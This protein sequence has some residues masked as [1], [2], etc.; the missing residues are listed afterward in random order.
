MQQINLELLAGIFDDP[1]ITATFEEIV[2][3]YTP[4]YLMGLEDLGLTKVIAEISNSGEVIANRKR[5]EQEIR[6]GKRN[7]DSLIGIF[8]GELTKASKKRVPIGR[9]TELRA[10]CERCDVDVGFGLVGQDAPQEQRKIT[11]DSLIYSAATET[12]GEKGEKG[13]ICPEC[14]LEDRIKTQEEA[15]AYIVRQEMT[16]EEKIGQAQIVIDSLAESWVPSGGEALQPE[17][18]YHILRRQFGRFYEFPRAGRTEG[19][20]ADLLKLW[21]IFEK[22]AHHNLDATQ[23]RGVPLGL[24]TALATIAHNNVSPPVAYFRVS[25]KDFGSLAD[26]T[27]AAMTPADGIPREIADKVRF[28]ISLPSKKGIERLTRFIEASK[29]WTVDKEHS[30]DY[31]ENEHPRS[32][33]YKSVHRTINFGGTPIEIQLRLYED[34][35]LIHTDPELREDRHRKRKAEILSRAPVHIRRL[36]PAL[37]VPDRYRNS[38]VAYLDGLIERFH[39]EASQTTNKADVRRDIAITSTMLSYVVELHERYPELPPVSEEIKKE[40]LDKFERHREETFVPIELNPDWQKIQGL[41]EVDLVPRVAYLHR[42]IG[43]PKRL[44]EPRYSRAIASGFTDETTHLARLGLNPQ[45][46]GEAITVLETNLGEA[47]IRLN[48]VEETKNGE[49]FYRPIEPGEKTIKTIYK[50][51]PVK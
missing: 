34:D 31:Y 45:E 17:Q 37:F 48:V 39:Q 46:I 24:R 14:G 32:P 5:M 9:Y 21:D 4:E 12:F 47:A 13:I 36:I 29:H 7:L 50:Y 51:R 30:K 8:F 18:I 28:R 6:E 3:R 15:S 26:K 22:I 20:N 16:E 42:F 10:Y 23:I 43:T 44:Y 35:Y 11:K 25:I 33:G 19:R 1:E 41:S 27:V 49:T 38:N 40:L 2:S